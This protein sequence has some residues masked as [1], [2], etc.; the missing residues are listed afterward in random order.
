MDT[1]GHFIIHGTRVEWKVE[2]Y[3][4][5]LM[6]GVQEEMINSINNGFCHFGWSFITNGGVGLQHISGLKLI[7]CTDAQ[8]SVA[9]GIKKDDQIF[10]HSRRTAIVSSFHLSKFPFIEKMICLALQKHSLNLEGIT[11]I[12]INLIWPGFSMAK[13]VDGSLVKTVVSAIALFGTDSSETT[14]LDIYD[15]KD[16]V[17]LRL[18]NKVTSYSFTTLATT[19]QGQKAGAGELL[20]SHSKCLNCYGIVAVCRK[21]HDHAILEKNYKGRSTCSAIDKGMQLDQLTFMQKHGKIKQLT[22]LDS[23]LLLSNLKVVT[24]VVPLV[25][26]SWFL[27][28]SGLKLELSCAASAGDPLPALSF[29]LGTTS[30]EALIFLRWILSA[31]HCY[32]TRGSSLIV[33]CCLNEIQ[34]QFISNSNVEYV[35]P[36]STKENLC[37]WL[38]RPQTLLEYIISWKDIA[39]ADTKDTLYNCKPFPV[40]AKVDAN[41]VM[42]KGFQYFGM[43]KIAKCAKKQTVWQ[44]VLKPVQ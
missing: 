10:P 21:F 37:V 9:Y 11:N 25:P 1:D 15:D 36:T 6:A 18:G 34:H 38:D 28:H 14:S 43:M 22:D 7:L 44:L 41:N 31:S 13:H 16:K 8:T 4:S 24:H 20:H 5:N 29:L 39:L 19:F 17:V 35:Y 26:G 40:F 2:P 23:H 12:E 32:H 27:Q 42:N 30:R 33:S 3:P